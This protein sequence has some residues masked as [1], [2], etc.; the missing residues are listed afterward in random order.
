VKQER[1][2][3]SKRTDLNEHYNASQLRMDTWNRLKYAVRRLE[4]RHRHGK[5]ASQIEES[6][7]D[8]LELLEPIE[9][10]WAFPGKEVMEQLEDLFE[11]KEYR[12]LANTINHVVRMLASESYR[13]R[14][15]ASRLLGVD[16]MMTNAPVTEE[17]HGDTIGLNRHYFEVLFVDNLSEAEEQ[18]L[19]RRMIETIDPNDEFIYDIV[20]V[21]SF[22]DAL[23]AVRLNYNIQSCVIRY[24]IPFKSKYSLDALLPYISELPDIDLTEEAD[25]DLGSTLGQLIK[26]LRPELDLFLVVDSGVEEIAGGIHQNFQRIFYRQENY[27]D[28]HL[29]IRRGILE[30]YETPFFTALKEYSQRPTGVFHAMPVSRG[31]SIFKSHWIQDMS[32]FY[33]RNI[34]LAE[35]SATTGGLDSLL[36]PTGPL[37]K[38]QQM[39]ARAFGG[40]H[41][42]FVTNGTSTANKIVVQALV[43]PN[44]IVLIDR[45]CHKSHHYGL[46]LSGA[47]PVYLDSYP[48]EQYSMYGAVP[49]LE[50]KR[51]LL[52]LKQAGR[53]DRV[54]MLLL[55][56]CTFDGLVYNVKRVM[57]E[58]LAIKPDMIL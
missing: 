11:R 14:V 47:L 6:V 12:L 19:R 1:K 46:V 13:Q 55:T 5:S 39:A 57:E 38:A 44:D 56:N 37:K 10:Y 24:S 36:Q 32:Q 25:I 48:N 58:V 17:R 7:W 52:E 26:K 30:R 53:L 4:D 15:T 8:Y 51:T 35:T 18:A 45:D 22:E 16:R 42:F 33:G 54:K 3:A 23:I 40:Q 50:I 28:L 49:L 31:N 41:T 34:F 2:T 27:L 20:V 29:S 43:Q 21:P 9:S